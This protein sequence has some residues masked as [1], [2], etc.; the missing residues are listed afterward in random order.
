[1]PTSLAV[2]ENRGLA[3]MRRKKRKASDGLIQKHVGILEQLALVNGGYV[4]TFSWLNRRGYFSSYDM[5]CQYP[6]A[7]AHLKR[8]S[9]KKFE[10]YEAAKSGKPEILPPDNAILAPAQYKSLADYNV[11][12]ARL[13]PTE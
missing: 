3:A 13:S 4:P 11:Q 2:I 10:I 12:G 1:M 7:F 6:A 9:E 8:E 5:M